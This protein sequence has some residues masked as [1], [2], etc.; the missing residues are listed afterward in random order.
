[1]TQRQPEFEDPTP[2]LP[3][4]QPEKPAMQKAV[5]PVWPRRIM[6]AIIIVAVAAIVLA[7]Y[8][9]HQKQQIAPSPTA[10]V[11]NPQVQPNPEAAAPQPPPLPTPDATAPMPQ[12]AMPATNTPAP[13]NPNVPQP[14]PNPNVPQP[15]PQEQGPKPLMD[16]HTAQAVADQM[17]ATEK[18][19]LVNGLHYMATYLRSPQFQDPDNWE[20]LQAA[21]ATSGL[22]MIP[23]GASIGTA[24]VIGLITQ[25]K[26]G[27]EAADNIEQYSYNLPSALP[28]AV[29]QQIAQV[30]ATA[31]D[32]DQ[33][34]SGVQGVLNG[35]GIKI[36]QVTSNYLAQAIQQAAQTATQG[37]PAP[38]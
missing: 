30:L 3:P 33:A 27:N 5:R 21:M 34:Y 2:E 28:Q 31:T 25:A 7:V 13:N 24:Q 23:G 12:G 9:P 18:G 29:K 11:D 36:S 20:L 37:A 14:N 6:G 32:P 4:A 1:M 10:T 16:P 26:N 35:S 22:S 8:L 38:R 17:D 15:Q 19:E